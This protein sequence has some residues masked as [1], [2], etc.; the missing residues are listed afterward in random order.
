MFRAPADAR[1]T[2]MAAISSGSFARFSGM[3]AAR[4]RSISCK[5]TPSCC[6]RTCRLASDR[7]VRVTPG[8][9]ALTLILCLANLLRCS[10]R[11]ADH[12]T[13]ACRV[14]RVGSARVTLPGD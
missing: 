10:L 1:N 11:Q 12:R 6:A 5:L 14:R 7:A 2:T 4:R 3:T 8:Q 9:T 13:F